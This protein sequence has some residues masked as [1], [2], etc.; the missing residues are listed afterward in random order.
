M[1]AIQ[2]VEWL[3]PL[4]DRERNRELERY[5]RQQAGLVPPHARFF[6]ACPWIMRADVDLDTGFQ[7]ING[8][9][10]LIYLVVS[11]D[12]SCRFCYGASRMFMRMSG[13]SDEE[14][15][16]LEQDVETARLEPPTRLA[17]DF[18]RRVSRSNPPPDETDQKALAEAG[19][20]KTAIRE[21]AF[22]AAQV[23]FHNRFA[24]LLA[25]PPR[26]AERLASSWL[27]H[28]VRLPF[29][30][31]LQRIETQA[32]PEALEE[33]LK[34]G[35]YTNVVLA[36]DGL[37]QARVLRGI[38]DEAW[39]SPHLTPR[40][41]ALVFAV[42]ARGIGS[43]HAER[44]ALRLLVAE[45]LEPQQVEEMLSHL[46]SPDL[47]P[48]EARILPYVRE[49]IWYQPA[50]LQRRGRELREQLGNARLLETVGIAALA[51]MVCRLASVL[52]PP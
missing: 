8:L 51:N 2:E 16:G 36:L 20:S 50:V 22:F 24:S 42:I 40:T 46:A 7:E 25:L 43:V 38:L 27:V 17:L 47:D 41:K 19:F 10:G 12:N 21:V 9:T 52:D 5:V 23:V 33:G 1:T 44:E 48:A 35:P 31:L 15:Q 6:G 26:A 28:L 34:T 3:E 29:R 4:A 37:P 45:G 18:A 30:R 13:M 49:T 32:R 39:A 11:R 14:I